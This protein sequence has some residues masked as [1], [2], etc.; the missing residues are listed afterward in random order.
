MAFFRHPILCFAFAVL[1]SSEVLKDVL[2]PFQG[3]PDALAE[4][5]PTIPASPA[6]T[7][8]TVFVPESTGAGEKVHDIELPVETVF[9]A[10]FQ[11]ER[12]FPVWQD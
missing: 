2:I 10:P 4:A 6:E 8:H 1:V 5:A 12:E 3:L 7:L 9:G 11:D